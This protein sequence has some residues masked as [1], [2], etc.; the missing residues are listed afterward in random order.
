M[1]IKRVVDVSFW[2]DSTVLDEYS[3]E[4]KYFMLYL[5]TNPNSE[6]LGLYKLPIKIISFETG[7]TV[8]VVR[9]LL[10]RFE[11][12]YQIIIYDYS[13]QEIFIK[14]FIKKSMIKGGKPVYDAFVSKWN[15]LK[16][17]KL[18]KEF[19]KHH[20]NNEIENKTLKDF[21]SYISYLN[22]DSN[23]NDYDYDYD[24]D[25]HVNVSCN[26]SL[27]EKKNVYFE[28]PLI[29]ELFINFLENRIELFG[30][31]INTKHS[32]NLLVNKLNKYDDETKEQMINNS[33][34]NSWKGIFEIK[35]NNFKSKQKVIGNMNGWYQEEEK[36]L[37]EE[38]LKELEEIRKLM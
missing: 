19:K 25:R 3:V 23:T 24:Y 29:N 26:V 1:A 30:K 34:E 5:F 35:Q 28:N 32:I 8:E 4:D 9:T 37:T 13:T 18:K 6:L 7:Y 16:S 12:K 10:E 36:E 33:L 27:N 11:N 17:D 20:S 31:K 21:I 38:E 14:N 15:S 22:I 2:K